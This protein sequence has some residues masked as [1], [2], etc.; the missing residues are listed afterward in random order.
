[1]KLKLDDIA[2]TLKNMQK[3]CSEQGNSAIQGRVK[4][5]ENEVIEIRNDISG[6]K[7]KMDGLKE[8]L[9]DANTKYQEVSQSYKDFKRSAKSGGT[10]YIR[11]GRKN[12]PGNGSELIYSGYAGG[13]WYGHSGA[14]VS[15]LCLT[16]NPD[17]AKYTSSLDSESAFVYGAE[18]ESSS[19]RTDKFFGPGHVQHD[20]PCAVCDVQSRSS[21]IMIPGKTRCHAGWTLEYSGYLMSGY[22][23]HAAARDYHCV[24]KYAETLNGGDKN[25]NGY[26]LY[27]VEGRCGSLKCPPYVSGRELTCAVCTK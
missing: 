5:L 10:T 7:R 6:M 15:M 13:S 9:D 23:A 19:S 20:V 21:H 11:W 8:D 18:Y 22:H 26:L 17:W 3:P 1:M 25:D 24:D 4:Q 12:C 2:D 14:A 27:F 16:T